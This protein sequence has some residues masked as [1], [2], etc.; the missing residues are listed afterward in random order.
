MGSGSHSSKSKSKSKSLA[1]L[2]FAS[3]DQDC[4]RHTSFGSGSSYTY[5]ETYSSDW[6]EEPK[7]HNSTRDLLQPSRK[8]SSSSTKSTK[9]GSPTA[10]V[11]TH[12]GRHSDQWLFNGNVSVTGIFKAFKKD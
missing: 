5:S 11:Y 1:P 8:S 4:Q 2:A 7:D 6:M 3:Y 12:C 9:P 10:N